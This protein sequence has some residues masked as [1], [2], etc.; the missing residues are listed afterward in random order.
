MAAKEREKAEGGGGAMSLFSMI[1]LQGFSRKN[2]SW[3]QG[4]TDIKGASAIERQKQLIVSGRKTFY[5]K[6]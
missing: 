3:G 1:Y 4:H 5:T 6:I 2:K